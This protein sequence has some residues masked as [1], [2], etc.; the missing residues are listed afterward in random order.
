M[1]G[2]AYLACAQRQPGPQWQCIGRDEGPPG[3]L[4]FCPLLPFFYCG[5]ALQHCTPSCMKAYPSKALIE[6]S[7]G[8]HGGVAIFPKHRYN[9]VRESG[10]SHCKAFASIDF[11][12]ISAF[13]SYV[14]IC[15]SLQITIEYGSANICL[16]FA[17]NM[18]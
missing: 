3:L 7:P 9:E 17:S 1:L 18:N 15:G 16:N 5:G 6:V 2:N 11:H 10:S 12:I 8:S 14:W 13:C 4:Q